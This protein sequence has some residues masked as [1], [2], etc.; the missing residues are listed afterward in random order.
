MT[1]RIVIAG[2]S[3]YLG[4]HLVAA[5]KARGWRVSALVRS[6]AAARRAGIATSDAAVV[7]FA[8]DAALLEVMRDAD[9]AISALGLT[10]QKGRRTYDDVDYRV[11]LR[12]LKA[13]LKGGVPRFGYVHVLNGE[14]MPGSALAR[15]K[16]RFVAAL[17]GAAIEPVV[18]APSGYYSDMEDF[19]SM[20]RRGTAFLIGDGTRRINPIHGADLAAVCVEAMA[21]GPGRVNVGGPDVLTHAEI[22]EMAFASLGRPARVTRIPEGL[23]RFVVGGM[24]L[25]GPQRMW[26]PAEF[27]LQAS[28]MDMVG[29]QKGARSLA[30]HFQGLAEGKG[31]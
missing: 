17:E 13:A 23:A 26:G 4:R 3:G 6:A 15:A 21:A 7:N 27:F 30:A 5:W 20:A 16:C 24:K 12:L 10:R 2:A 22:A 1:E 25:L 8:D 11:N 29:E 31:A 19:L 9:A 14:N 28:S 18:I